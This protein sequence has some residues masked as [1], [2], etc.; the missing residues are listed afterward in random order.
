MNPKFAI[1]SVLSA[2]MVAFAA[3]AGAQDGGDAP[4]IQ[5]PSGEIRDIVEKAR[6]DSKAVREDARAAVQATNQEARDARHDTLSGAREEVH[7]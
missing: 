7:G 4:Q 2:G 1:L 3:P 5:P 6:A